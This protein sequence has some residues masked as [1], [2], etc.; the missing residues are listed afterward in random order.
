MG[1]YLLLK[2]LKTDDMD[3]EKNRYKH[4]TNAAI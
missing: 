3:E 4:L 1:K 2:I